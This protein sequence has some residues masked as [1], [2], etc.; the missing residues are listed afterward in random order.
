MRGRE[1][2]TR[3]HL[4][5]MGH[6][7]LQ[8][9]FLSVGFAACSFVASRA[10]LTQNFTSPPSDVNPPLSG[11]ATSVRPVSTTIE[12]NADTQTTLQGA[13]VPYHVTQAE[14]LSSAGTF[15][16]FTRYLQV[17]P[18]VAWNSDISNDV[19]VQGGHPSENLYVLDGI[20][21]PNINHLAVEGTTGGF[22]AMLDTSSISSVDLNSGLYDASYSSRLSSMIEIR[23]HESEAGT[24]EGEV[25]FGIGGIGGFWDLPIGKRGSALLSAHRSL[26]NLVT[27]NI[28]ID[29]TPTYTDG[30]AR[31]QWSPNGKDRISILSLNGADSIDVTPCAGDPYESLLI[32][33]QYS[34]ARSTHGMVWQHIRGTMGVST[35]SASYSSDDQSI[36]Q[37]QQN[38]GASEKN[39]ENSGV[40]CQ[41]IQLTTVY[42]E[43]THDGIASV[44]YKVQSGLRDWVISEG[45]TGRLTRLDYAV[46]QPEGQQS[47]FNANPAWT[48]SDSFRRNFETGQTGAFA[49]ITGHVG[50]RWTLTTGAR[51]ETF[52]LTAAKTFTPRG[53]LAY[54][55]DEHQS[56]NVSFDRSAQ[57][58]PAI[59]ILSFAQNALLRPIQVEQFSASADLWR[60]NWA[61]A[62]ISFYRKAYSSEPVSTEYPSLMLA[63]MVDTLG[64]QFVWIPL[65]SG[66][67]GRSQGAELLL[68]AHWKD[69]VQFLG[70][71][72]YSRTRYAAADG[73]MR[74]G[75]YDFPL[76]GN[77]LTAIH[78]PK[79]FMLSVR[80]TYASGR[81]YTP[82]NVALSE[83]QARGIYD[84]TRVNALRGPAYNRF[85]FD[86]GR[87]FRIR[88]GTLTANGGMQNAFDRGNFLGYAWL[89]RCLASEP[90]A[91]CDLNGEPET[92]VE[93][94]PHFPSATIRFDF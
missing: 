55:I 61:A 84:L 28:G 91:K 9:F 85:D 23:T 44:N 2:T 78:F 45:V 32:D 82:F 49:E 1:P 62:Q 38:P 5:N 7:R 19:M 51:E 24:S 65:R 93:Q 60:T 69:R 94:M 17:L 57:L 77:G 89:D 43:K 79:A 76:I 34:G 6:K 12:V 48:D 63:N 86:I 59:N 80:D 14:V 15:E 90:A 56:L 10:A 8:S 81:P 39:W 16:D 41:P 64:Q 67:R 29:G 88:K 53:S 54:R 30:L 72:T 75:N 92:K 26:L 73:V 37:Q 13:A 46:A 71:T 66:G 36:S 47:P 27:D 3:K 83:E 58:A 31:L 42:G 18:G 50:K 22:T 4:M 35:L 87:Q 68:R 33:T 21:V 11:A 74:A 20:E 70:S 40:Y 25:N 52:A